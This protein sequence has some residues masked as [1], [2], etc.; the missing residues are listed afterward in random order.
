MLKKCWINSWISSKIR[1]CEL[2]TCYYSL[3]EKPVTKLIHFLIF[4]VHLTTIPFT[5]VD[6]PTRQN[7]D[8]LLILG[9][10]Y[11]AMAAFTSLYGIISLW[12]RSVIISWWYLMTCNDIDLQDYWLSPYVP[13]VPSLF[14]TIS[15]ILRWGSNL[16]VHSFETIIN[17]YHKCARFAPYHTCILLEEAFRGRWALSIPA[18]Q[19]FLSRLLQSLVRLRV[20][21]GGLRAETSKVKCFSETVQTNKR[22]GLS[23]SRI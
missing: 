17:L 9:A 20:C 14:C 3:L 16:F 18:V 13:L 12:I 22:H 23:R 15:I 6:D 4:F 11:L 19:F 1:H 2:V 8:Y 21:F 10:N 7:W 5:N